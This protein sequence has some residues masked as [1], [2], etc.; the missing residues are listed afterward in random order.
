MV[1]KIALH[2]VTFI[3]LR[4]A[5]QKF[6]PYCLYWQI[7]LEF[8]FIYINVLLSNNYQFSFPTY[9]L[10]IFFYSFI[11]RFFLFKFSGFSL[12]LYSWKLLY[13]PSA[14]ST[15]PHCLSPHTMSP[16][17][18]RSVF[19]PYFV[20]SYFPADMIFFSFVQLHLSVHFHFAIFRVLIPG[21]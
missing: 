4:K 15:P 6:Q 13:F 7:L 19:L 8:S 14:F 3:R 10:L 21:L 2:P 1:S 20:H 12:R 9:I 18:L 5:S 16:Q 11:V 17:L